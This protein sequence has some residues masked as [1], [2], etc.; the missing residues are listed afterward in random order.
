MEEQE[1]RQKLEK[2]AQ[3]N[4][5]QLNPNQDVTNKIISL[6]LK[7]AQEK[8]QPYCPCRVQTGD[9]KKDKLIICPCVYNMGEIELQGR[10]HCNLFWK[11]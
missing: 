9:E 2:H 1:L 6:L 4:D 5:V 11:K 3:E 7:N 8:G 10:C